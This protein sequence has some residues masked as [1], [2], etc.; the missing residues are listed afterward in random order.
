MPPLNES[1]EPLLEARSI[2]MKFGGLTA[3]SD[4]SLVVQPGTVTALIGPNGAGKSTMVEILSGFRLPTSGDVLFRGTSILGVKPHTL[5]QHGMARSFQDVEIFG[6]LTVA[7]NIALACQHQP[8]DSMWTLLTRWRRSARGQAEVRAK[9]TDILHRL[10]L[11]AHADELTGNL[12]YGLQK[13]VIV[14]RL[15]ATDAELLILDE[16]GAGLPRAAVRELGELL[17]Q[18]VA[19]EDRTVLLIDH[20]MELV[21]EFAD[22]VHV[23]HTGRVIVSGPPA[24]IRDNEEVLDVYLSRTPSKSASGPAS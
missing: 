19:T 12:S 10:G 3:L 22:M 18:V 21:L 7:E 16:P 5:V 8:D 24:E 6:L 23:L 11:F 15:L 14:G 13:Q 4:A 20:N 2:T 1:T 17:R 9:V